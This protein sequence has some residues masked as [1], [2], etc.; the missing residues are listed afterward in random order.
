[1]RIIWLVKRLFPDERG[2][3]EPAKVTAELIQSQ[4]L[5]IGANK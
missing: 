3:L 1:M 5:C 4:V 2:A